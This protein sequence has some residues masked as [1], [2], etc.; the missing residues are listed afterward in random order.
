[1]K[2]T[3]P[4][5]RQAAE[6]GLL[7]QQQSEQ[8]W[9]FLQTHNQYDPGFKAGNILYYLGGMLVIGAMSLFMSLGW[10][11]FG[12][13]GLFSITLAYAFVA[14]WQTEFLLQQRQLPIPAGITAALVVVLTPLAVFGLQAGLGMWAE[15]MLYRDN[16]V[17]VDSR[18]LLMELATL[19]CAVVM[20]WRYRLPFL[21]MPLA[22]TI[23]CMS[24]EAV[25]FLYG[26]GSGHWELRR[27]FAL[28]S[29]LL[30]V[31]LA[32]WIDVRS[33]RERDFSFWLYLF[34]VLSFWWAFS[35]FITDNELNNFFYMCVN[36]LMIALGA[37]LSRRVFVVC[38]GFGVAGYLGHLSYRVFDGSLLFLLCLTLIGFALIY[39]G[40]LWQRRE[41]QIRN[42]L[43]QLLPQQLR[44]LVEGLG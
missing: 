8:L 31:L 17:Y 24:M 2:I 34:G 43:L 41:E 4:L 32:F 15:G 13:W 23:W 44:K 16:H 33:S 10:E 27:F 7:S 9:Q 20:L 5:L 12:G 19:V 35:S 30:M 21:V 28:W 3:R 42:R 1:M 26:N 14:L 40:I 11:R 22:V 29:G 36:L 39:A 38:G 37:M 6:E 18:W 25:V